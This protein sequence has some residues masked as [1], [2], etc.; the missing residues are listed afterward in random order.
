M[1]VSYTHLDSMTKT[2]YIK[3]NSPAIGFTMS[4][5]VANCPPLLVNFTN[6]S[7]GVSSYVWTFGNGGQSS[8]ANPTALYT[9][10]GVYNI[11]LIGTTNAGCKDSLTKH[12]TI[13]GP[14]G[15]FTYTPIAGCN[16]VTVNF[17]ATTTNAT[18][19]IWDMSNGFTQTTTGNTYSYTYTQTGKYVPKLLSLIHI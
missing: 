5:T 18:S 12:V 2:A 17:S 7:S 11:K 10:P 19:L 9:Y 6:T 16:P 3:I 1:P 13:Y 15:S 4:D 8:L 14:T